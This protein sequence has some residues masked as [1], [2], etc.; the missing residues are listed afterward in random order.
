MKSSYSCFI[1]EFR[2]LSKIN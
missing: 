2:A 1:T